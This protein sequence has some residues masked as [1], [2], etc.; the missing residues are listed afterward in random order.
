MKVKLLFLSLI[1]LIAVTV[2]SAKDVFYPV[3]EIAAN[4]LTDANSV[5]R[6]SETT[7][8][9]FSKTKIRY[10][11]KEVITIFN[12]NGEGEGVLLIPYDS[13]SEV[14][15]KVANFYDKEGNLIKKVKKSEVYDQTMFDGFSM[16]TDGRF[17]RI[18]PQISTYPYTVEYECTIEQ[19]GAIDFYNWMPCD[20]YNKSIVFASYK[21]LDYEDEGIRIKPNKLVNTVKNGELVDGVKTYLWELENMEAM[22]HEPLAVSMVNFVPRVVVAPLNFEFYGTKGSMDSWKAFG[23]WVYSLIEDRNDLPEDRVQFLKELTASVDDPVEKIKLVYEL[24]QKNT[25][26]VSI[27]LGIGGFQPFPAQ[28]VEEVGYGDCKALTN[29]MKSMLQSIGIESYYTLVKA[30]TNTGEIDVDFPS[31]NFNHVILTVPVES[32]T[33]FLECTSQFSPFGFQGSFTSERSALLIDKNNSRLI[34]TKNYGLNENTWKMKASIL[35]NE[36][37]HAVVNDTVEFNGLQYE[38]IERDLRKTHED[39]IEDAYKTGNIPGAN[40]RTIAYENRPE[41][42]PSAT[43]T[44]LLEVDRFATKMGDRMFVPVNSLNKHSSVPKKASDRKFPFKTR[45]SYQDEDCVT[46]V[47]PEGYEIEYLPE[48]VKIETEFGAYQSELKHSQNSIVYTRRNV[49]NRGVFPPEKYADYVEFT[50]KI[51]DADSQKMILKKK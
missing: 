49:K 39:I 15:I 12:E 40:Y 1:L 13:N 37:G 20:A 17:K 48:P 28:K 8:E 25:R 41:R 23:D 35:V 16:Y 10:S 44:R 47:I 24:L 2:T 26:Y 50:R 6:T 5:V 45:L 18:T 3:S 7:L 9:I 21:I 31:Q 43:R 22:E 32:D 42:I 11:I 34:Q 27:Q 14:D 30:G 38:Y 19:K 51:V 46:F 4:L 36:S 33:I 29:Y